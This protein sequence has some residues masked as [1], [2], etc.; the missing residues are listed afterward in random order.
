MSKLTSFIILSLALS[1]YSKETC[2]DFIYQVPAYS[3]VESDSLSTSETRFLFLVSKNEESK[4]MSDQQGTEYLMSVNGDN[5]MQEILTVPFLEQ[6]INGVAKLVEVTNGYRNGNIYIFESE[7]ASLRS[8]EFIFR[9][10]ETPFG[11]ERVL[12]RF[13]AG[14]LNILEQLHSQLF[15]LRD[16]NLGN[17]MVTE[18]NMPYIFNF[19]GVVSMKENEY[20]LDTN[21]E[22][23]QKEII[24]N[25]NGTKMKYDG[26]SDVFGLGVVMYYMIFNYYPFNTLQFDSKKMGDYKITFIGQFGENSATFCTDLLKFESGENDTQDLRNTIS[27]MLE[28][29]SFPPSTYNFIANIYGGIKTLESNNEQIHVESYDEPVDNRN[30]HMNYVYNEQNGNSVNF[31]PVKKN[32]YQVEDNFQGKTYNIPIN[33]EREVDSQNNVVMKPKFNIPSEIFKDMSFQGNSGGPD[34]Q[35]VIIGILIVGCYLFCISAIV[36]MVIAGMKNYRAFFGCHF[37]GADKMQNFGAGN[38]QYNNNFT[39]QQDTNYVQ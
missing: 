16:F 39:P 38:G 33:W 10:M 11:D 27:E 32:N 28:D 9:K 5:S 34:A 20:P 21:I 17:I 18:D 1:M 8:L 3:C 15:V 25:S 6:N 19:N 24:H 30:A 26:R 12:L 7:H 4:M 22:S 35:T 2:E 29:N 31:S 36:F 13:V 37:E 14:F 23:S